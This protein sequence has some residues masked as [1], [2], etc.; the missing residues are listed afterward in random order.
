MNNYLASPINQPKGGLLV[1]HAWWGLNDF[2]KKECNRLADEGY[3]TLAPD[4]YDGKIAATVEQAETLRG[5]TKRAVV[6][7]KILAALDFL[8]A[9]P[10]MEQKAIGLVGFSLGAWWSLWLNEQRPDQ[11]AATVLFY[12]TRG[13]KSAATQSAFLGHFAEHDPYTP[14][15]GVKRLEK[16]LKA[17]GKVTE[18]HT[19]AGTGHWFFEQDRPEYHPEAANLAWARTLE[20]LRIHFPA[21][22][23]HQ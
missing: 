19:Y 10:E 13:M 21:A 20:F 17:A 11:I 1:L 18:F 4:L 3:L 7:T 9:R 23:D 6:E 2:F 8:H 22:K 14:A 5:K 16:T 12:G 15:S